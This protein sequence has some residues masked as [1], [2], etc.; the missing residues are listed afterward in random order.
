MPYRSPL[1]ILSQS[2]G[3]LPVPLTPTTRVA[4]HC[5]WN[6]PWAQVTDALAIR[7]PAKSQSISTAPGVLFSADRRFTRHLRLHVG[8]P[9]GPAVR[10]ALKLLGA[11]VRD[12]SVADGVSL[13]TH[14]MDHPS[15][16]HWR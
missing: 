1:D 13:L 15:R 3:L 10:S 11:N 2:D 9:V 12:P 6:C 4:T 8:H 16:I 7:H 14:D 5:G